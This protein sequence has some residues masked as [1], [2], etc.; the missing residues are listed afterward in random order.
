VREPAGVFTAMYYDESGALF[1]MRRGNSMFYVGSDHLGTPRVVVDATGAAVKVMEYDSFG[2]PTSDSNTSFR[3]P[4]GFAGGIPDVTGLE[5]F[6]FRDYEPATGRWTHRDPIFFNSR[7]P[8]LYRYVENDPIN[9]ADKEGLR[10]F[11]LPLIY[12]L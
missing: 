3:L 11:K 10:G 12:K 6:G 4:I 2:Y 5:R 9:F 7:Q 1:A 8:N